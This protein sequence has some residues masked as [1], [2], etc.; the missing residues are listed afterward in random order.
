MDVV[1]FVLVIVNVA[2]V[3]AFCAEMRGMFEVEDDS[4]LELASMAGAR[5]GRRLPL[6][7]S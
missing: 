3:A 7:F 5:P 1:P 4:T 2:L 6:A